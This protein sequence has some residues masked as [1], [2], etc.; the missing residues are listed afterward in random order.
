VVPGEYVSEAVDLRHASLRP[1]RPV[2]LYV[3]GKCVCDAH[4]L[5]WSRPILANQLEPH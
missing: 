2:T 5:D 4:M 1:E 3:D